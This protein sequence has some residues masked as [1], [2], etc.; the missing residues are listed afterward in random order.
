MNVVAIRCVDATSG[1]PCARASG[2]S[3]LK[4][5]C[6]QCVVSLDLNL[7]SLTFLGPGFAEVP[8]FMQPRAALA[9][10][11]EA[12]NRTCLLSTLRCPFANSTLQEVQEGEKGDR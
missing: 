10:S 11:L 8:S 12:K 3:S 5:S 1:S 9:I 6:K 7:I 2:R 4:K